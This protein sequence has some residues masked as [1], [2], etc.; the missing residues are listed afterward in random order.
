MSI[1]IWLNNKVSSLT[2]DKLPESLDQLKNALINLFDFPENISKKDLLLFFLDEDKDSISLS[3]SS[4]YEALKS[5]KNHKI[6][7]KIPA[8]KLKQI[9]EPQKF[10]LK[11]LGFE[12]LETNIQEII[13]R[14]LS[15]KIPLISKKIELYYSHKNKCQTKE[16]ETQTEE[17]QI[18]EFKVDKI[19]N[20][21]EK[22]E[23]LF[24]GKFN[25]DNEK[26]N[27]IIYFPEEKFNPKEQN[28][29]FSNCKSVNS[30]K[31]EAIPILV[32]KSL[33]FLQKPINIKYE[34]ILVSLTLQNSS[35]NP[36][37]PGFFSLKIAE[38]FCLIG[39]TLVLVDFKPSETKEI[40]YQIKNPGAEGKFGGFIDIFVSSN[41]QKT[42]SFPIEFYVKEEKKPEL[43]FSKEIL[44]KG[45]LVKEILNCEEEQY[46][47]VLEFFKKNERASVEEAINNYIEGN[48]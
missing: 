39:E 7:I 5:E 38:K 11:E 25:K 4:D 27:E 13:I 8:E 1:E 32:L 43:E 3:S 18:E 41:G 44:E 19:E 15:E 28:E 36:I 34:F 48:L 9:Q 2:L 30:T 24:N 16:C 20:L 31:E 23:D 14:Y 35:L 37:K 12:S 22:N 17:E 33:D 42:Q 47:K 45:M 6:L 21:N 26:P 29:N 10:I 40:I 46:L